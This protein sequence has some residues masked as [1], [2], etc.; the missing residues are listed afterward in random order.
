[1]DKVTKAFVKLGEK[2]VVRI[3]QIIS[4]I[5]GGETK[6]LDIKRLVNHRDIFRVRVGKYRI[7]F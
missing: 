1:M 6:G 7:I 4:L 3:Q 2:N 5:I